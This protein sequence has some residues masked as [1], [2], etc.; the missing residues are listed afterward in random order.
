MQ[1]F[2]CYGFPLTPAPLLL[3]VG[4]DGIELGH[5]VALPMHFGFVLLHL[6]V[7]FN[8]VCFPLT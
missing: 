4:L 1:S 2:I 7:G 6:K 8:I 3:L 5:L